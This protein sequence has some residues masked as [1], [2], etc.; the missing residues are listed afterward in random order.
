MGRLLPKRFSGVSAVV[1]GHGVVVT[2]KKFTLSLPL[3]LCVFEAFHSS[4][5]RDYLSKIPRSTW[6]RCSTL[7]AFHLTEKSGWSTH[8]QMVSDSPV[9]IWNR[10][11]HCLQILFLFFKFVTSETK[12]SFATEPMRFWLASIREVSVRKR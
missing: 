11:H 8:Y 1:A 7:R 3:F 6:V 9:S 12:E 10:R 5:R 4:L 2:M